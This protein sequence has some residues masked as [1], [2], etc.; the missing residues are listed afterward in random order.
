LAVP[1]L[2]TALFAIF[3]LF[4]AMPETCFE[5]VNAKGLAILA[6][7][8]ESTTDAGTSFE[9]KAISPGFLVR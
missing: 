9:R 3:F 4:F 1:S 8:L 5:K 7:L 6:E 2:D